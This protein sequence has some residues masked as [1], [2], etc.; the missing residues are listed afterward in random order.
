M[1]H[2]LFE[3]KKKV[4]K[5]RRKKD[6]DDFDSSKRK[7]G[8]T[9]EI[10]FVSFCTSIGLYREHIGKP[11]KKEI[12]SLKEMANMYS[13]NKAELYDFIVFG[14][15]NISKNRLEEFEKYFYAGFKFLKDWLDDIGIDLN[16]EVEIFCQFWDDLIGKVEL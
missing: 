8:F 2:E 7:L 9:D 3:G 6:L 12:P 11:L 14:Y 16:S 1:R 10:D 4:R 5:V 15:L 13:F